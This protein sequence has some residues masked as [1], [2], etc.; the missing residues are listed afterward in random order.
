MSRPTEQ[1][2]CEEEV[3]ELC[4]SINKKYGPCIDLE[5]LPGSLY[6]AEQRIAL[7]Q[8]ADIYFN[9]SLSEGLNLHPQEFICFKKVPG[10]VILSEFSNAAE[11]LNGA[12][13]IN[14]WNTDSMAHMRERALE[15]SPTD[16]MN[17]KNRDEKSIL[18]RKPSQ[19]TRQIME[20]MYSGLTG[21]DVSDSRAIL[22]EDNINYSNLYQPIPLDVSP[23]FCSFHV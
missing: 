7:W 2:R 15:M 13:L 10:V 4:Q 22:D 18:E 9:A 6:P 3:T 12:I 1:K 8:A 17:R 19:W 23:C 20:D 5:I 21:E 11:F 14:P 16:R